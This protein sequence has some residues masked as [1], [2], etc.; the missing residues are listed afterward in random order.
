VPDAGESVEK[1]WVL[2]TSGT[3]VEK[4]K[5][6]YHSTVVPIA[7]ATATRRSCLGSTPTVSV[8]PRHDAT[9]H[10]V[11]TTGSSRVPRMPWGKWRTATVW[12]TPRRW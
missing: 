10:P 6:S 11:V 7:L 3:A 9:L 1:N 8:M 4:M 12:S 2:N 5:K